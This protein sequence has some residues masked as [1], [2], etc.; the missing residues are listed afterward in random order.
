[1][2]QICID[3]N[4]LYVEKREQ[5]IEAIEKETGKPISAAGLIHEFFITIQIDE[6]ILEAKSL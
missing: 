4:D 3:I 5:I 1:M 2:T 6:N